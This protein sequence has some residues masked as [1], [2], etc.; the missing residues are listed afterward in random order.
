MV[1]LAAKEI[2]DHLVPLDLLVRP[3]NSPCCPQTS[4]SKE[5]PQ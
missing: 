1:L 2:E 5:M 4:C 3:E